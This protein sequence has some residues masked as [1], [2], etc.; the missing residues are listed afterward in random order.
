MNLTFAEIPESGE[1]PHA[2]GDDDVIRSIGESTKAMYGRSGFVRPWISYVALHGE[3][4]VGTCAFKSPP[5]AGRVEVAYFTLPGNEGRGIATAMVQRMI[6]IARKTDPRLTVVAQT[7]ME[8]S[9]ST[10]VLRKLGFRLARSVNHPEDGTVWEWE[11]PLNPNEP[12]TT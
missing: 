2:V 5:V 1:I 8:E 11:L 9:A 4:P 3:T 12:V 6:E 7:L 10:S